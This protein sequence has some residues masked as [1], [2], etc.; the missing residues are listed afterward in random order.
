EVQE[1]E[2]LGAG[3]GVEESVEEAPG[4][5]VEPVEVLEQ[6][7][8]RFALA[9]RLQEARDDTEELP[10]A[11][12]GVEE[13]RRAGGIGDAEEVEDQRQ[14]LV[15]ARVDQHQ[16]AG[17]LLPRLALAVLLG[18]AEHAAEELEERQERQQPAVSDPASLVHRDAA[19]AAALDELGA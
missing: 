12:G 2:R 11:I 4:P 13:R 8:V 15:E 10:L 3:D 7:H 18:E 14:R 17:D 5:L 16:R 1:H 9:E 6:D 19:R